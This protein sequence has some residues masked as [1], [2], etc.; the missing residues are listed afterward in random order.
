M[1]V[2]NVKFSSLAIEN[3]KIRFV[4]TRAVMTLKIN[5]ESVRAKKSIRLNKKLFDI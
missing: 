1:E 2:K 4:K 5:I 3:I